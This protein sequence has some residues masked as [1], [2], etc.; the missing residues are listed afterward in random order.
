MTPSDV[1]SDSLGVRKK[2]T[3]TLLLIGSTQLLTMNLR[4][5]LCSV[6]IGIEDEAQT[7]VQ[8][9]TMIIDGE[10]AVARAI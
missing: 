1:T 10:M 2:V 5:E 7:I 4:V 8:Y 9:K 3:E 6:L